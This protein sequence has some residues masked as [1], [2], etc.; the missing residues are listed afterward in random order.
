MRVRTLNPFVSRVPRRFSSKLVRHNLNCWPKRETRFSA[1]SH[2]W[3]ENINLSKVSATTCSFGCS[4][5]F[6]RKSK[7]FATCAFRRAKNYRSEFQL[8]SSGS[9]DKSRVQN[10]LQSGLVSCVIFFLLGRGETRK[11]GKAKKNS[12]SNRRKSSGVEGQ[13]FGLIFEI[14]LFKVTSD[15]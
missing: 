1:E 8:V 15:V 12:W 11:S 7:P 6:C 2:K 9:S 14:P 5:E 3:K 4:G 10:K 13:F